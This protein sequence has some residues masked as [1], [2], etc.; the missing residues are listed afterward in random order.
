MFKLAIIAPH[1]VQYH[2]PLFKEVEKLSNIDSKVL[3]CDDMGVEDIYEE[4]FKTTIKW[5]IPMLDGY[6]YEFLKNYSLKPYS[7][8]FSRVN[9]ALFSEISKNKYNSI[10]IQGYNTLSCWIAFFAAKLAGAKVIWR[11]ESTLKGDENSSLWKKHLKKIILSRFFNVCDAVMYSCSGN[12]DYL[13]FYGVPESKLF[14]IPCAVDNDFF[15]SEKRKYL[16]KENKI[17]K[18]LGI[19]EDDFVVLFSARFTSRKRPLDLLKAIKQINHDNMLVLFVGD[20]PE[21]SVMEKFT[22]D[23]HIKSLFTGFVNQSEISRYYSVS[24]IAVVISDYDPSPKAMN[25]AM[26]FELPIIATDVV[27]TAHDLVKDGVNGFIIKVG[28]INTTAAKIDYF[29]KNRLITKAMGKKSLDIVKNWNL[30]ADAK[31]VEKAVQ[32]VMN[33]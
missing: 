11:G 31:G 28:D 10:L 27:G 14:P 26:N 15:Q 20:G 7:G 13:Q 4:E 24:D 22:Q 12:K 18:G 16:G 33:Y 19:G 32:F 1:P 5:D 17:R 2:F 30:Q 25:E 23:Y 9:P 29:N 6:K 21:R 3:Y 8:F